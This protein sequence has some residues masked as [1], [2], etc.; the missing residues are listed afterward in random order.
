[1]SVLFRHRSR[2]RKRTRIHVSTDVRT[3]VTHASR[4][5]SEH[6]YAR[7]LARTI[8]LF[9]L[10][11][12]AGRSGHRLIP[13]PKQPSGIKLYRYCGATTTDKRTYYNARRIHRSAPRRYCSHDDC[14]KVVFQNT[15]F[16]NRSR[17]WKRARSWTLY[18]RI[19]YSYLLPWLFFF[20]FIIIFLLISTGVVAPKSDYS[21]V[22]MNLCDPRLIL[23]DYHFAKRNFG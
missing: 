13:R 16:A 9:I 4:F 5:I 18:A 20:F 22:T 1:V 12:F 3:R 2:P 19:T 11:L 23:Y 21:P 14:F 15:H 8:L 6:V 10:L 7:G 17:P